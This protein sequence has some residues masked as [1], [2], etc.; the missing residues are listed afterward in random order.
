MPPSNTPTNGIRTGWR[1]DEA[2]RRYTL[3]GEFDRNVK[4][5]GIRCVAA[6]PV[7]KRYVLRYTV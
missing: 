7:S 3:A 4:G 2:A 6:S 1:F 5:K